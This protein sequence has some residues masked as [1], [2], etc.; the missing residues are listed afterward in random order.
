MAKEN[1]KERN[2][3]IFGKWQENVFLSFG[4][5]FFFFKVYYKARHFSRLIFRQTLVCFLCVWE[6][7]KVTSGIHFYKAMMPSHKMTRSINR[8]LYFLIYR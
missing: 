2:E 5:F 3:K 6:R 1:Q 8:A 7:K 4:I